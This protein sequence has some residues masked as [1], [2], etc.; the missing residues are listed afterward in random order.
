MP[1]ATAR[2]RTMRLPDM[3]HG[4]LFER[5]E[6]YCA[7]GDRAPLHRQGSTAIESVVGDWRP[8]HDIKVRIPGMIGRQGRTFMTCE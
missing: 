7:P 5:P 2:F 8:D 4:T 1:M 3:P 6:K